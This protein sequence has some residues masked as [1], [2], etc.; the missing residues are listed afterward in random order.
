MIDVELPSATMDVGLDVIRLVPTTATPA[1]KST[2]AVSV[3]AP[4]FTVPVIVAVAVDVPL[5]KV[6][7]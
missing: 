5:V 4:P 7:L 2:E 6:A 3:I 1:T